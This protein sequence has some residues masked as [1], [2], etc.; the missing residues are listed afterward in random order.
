[1]IDLHSENNVVKLSMELLSACLYL[2]ISA[3]LL[4]FSL[5]ISTGFIKTVYDLTI[6]EALKVLIYRRA[7]GEKRRA[8]ENLEINILIVKHCFFK[9]N[10]LN[11]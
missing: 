1:V 8:T 6:S 9:I 2:L 5:F 11:Q 7:N 4:Q 3:F 10:K